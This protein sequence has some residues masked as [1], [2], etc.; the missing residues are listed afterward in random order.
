MPGCL[1]AVSGGSGDSSGRWSGCPGGAGP[2]TTAGPRVRTGVEPGSRV[3]ERPGPL[4]RTTATPIAVVSGTA[5]TSPIEPTKMLS[6]SAA[7]R[8][9]CTTSS[10]GRL[11]ILSSKKTPSDAPAVANAIV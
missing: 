8:S 3:E 4:T 11:L 10:S 6:S 7:N 2:L 5:N 1:V 9:A